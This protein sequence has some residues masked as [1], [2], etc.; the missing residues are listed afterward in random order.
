MLKYFYRWL[1]R[2]MQNSIEAGPQEPSLI[3]QVTVA[4]YVG[5]PHHGRNTL[6]FQLFPANGGWV[7]ECTGAYDNKRDEH[8]RS[9]HIITQDQDFAEGIARIATLELLKQ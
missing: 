7:V 5:T 8:M 4:N 9:L 3:G 6:G 2:K 1:Y